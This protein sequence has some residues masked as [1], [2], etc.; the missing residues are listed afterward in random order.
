MSRTQTLAV[1]VA[2]VLLAAGTAR[3]QQDTTIRID[4]RWRAYL[5]CW[6][7][8]TD[9]LAGPL[10][11]V[12][13]TSAPAT[14]ELLTMVEDSVVN[15]TSVSATGD[16]VRVT[17]DGC[18]GWETGRFSAD[19]RRV[20]TTANFTCDGG[21]TQQTQSLF[22][23][24]RRDTF[25]RTDGLK[26][27]SGATAVRVITF[28]AVTVD[29][30][31]VPADVAR[32]LPAMQSMP[33][34]AARI[35]ASALLSPADVADASQALDAAVVEA[36]LVARGEGI[37]LSAKQLRT[38]R[39]A[40]VPGTTTDVLIALANPRVFQIAKGGAPGA[41][42]NERTGVDCSV[43]PDLCLNG[44]RVG[45]FPYGFADVFDPFF[46][47]GYGYGG[48]GYNRFGL[49][50][51]GSCFSGFNCGGFG[52]GGNGLGWGNGGP[53]VIVPQ[54]VLPQREQGR[55]INGS[56]YSQRG[57]SDGGRTATPSSASGG[58]GSGASVSNGGGYSGG[59][60]GGSS[61]S[62]GGDRTAKP[63]P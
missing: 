46:G 50:Y 7:T 12:V 43:R 23:M 53:I 10:V 29:S 48:W 27:R 42:P 20:Y 24:V 32:R 41:R 58:G 2:G 8:R 35:E 63:R 39:D 38:M 9:D 34:Y 54:P 3:A 51:Y 47:M 60:G 25:T 37:A 15:R 16:R 28:S 21:V 49:G 1:A 22:S 5:G 44:R 14:V 17:R 30:L 6:E 18:A 59:G 40:K 13:P 26:T 56:G 45:S 19:D 31:E 36:W 55:A 4:E 11:C 52:W 61:A 57:A 62:G 33:T